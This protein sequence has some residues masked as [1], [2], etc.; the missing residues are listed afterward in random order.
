ML[1]FVNCRPCCVACERAF[2]ILFQK[3][4]LK[5]LLN[6]SY[7]FNHIVF[8]GLREKLIVFYFFQTVIMS[9]QKDTLYVSQ[10]LN[11][12]ANF[13][14]FSI[15][16]ELVVLLIYNTWSFLCFNEKPASWATQRH[17]LFCIATVLGSFNTSR[18]PWLIQDLKQD[19]GIGRT[20]ANQ[21]QSEH[22]TKVNSACR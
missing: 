14:V 6:K 18:D 16:D 22:L 7:I 1:Q 15:N 13:W 3:S 21:S 11:Y 2:C 5:Q 19:P 17:V 8:M 12:M 4:F 9:E 20:Q 10:S